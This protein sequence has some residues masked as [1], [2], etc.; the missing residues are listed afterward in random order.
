VTTALQGGRGRLASA[1]ELTRALGELAGPDG[2]TASASTFTRADVVD[3]LAKRLPVAPTAQ[4]AIEQAERVAERF[5]AERSVRVGQD[6]RLGVERYSTPEL[7]D[8]EQ[9]LVA[10]AL[11]RRDERCGMVRPEVVRAVLDRH[12]TV[13]PDQAAMVQDVCRSGAGV[14]PVVGRA[15]SG[16][17]WALGLAREA[18]ELD[19]YRVLGA[20]PTGIAAVGLGDE[21]FSEVATVDRLLYDLGRGSSSWTPGRCWWSMRPPCLA[22]A[23]SPRCSA[24]PTTP[25]PR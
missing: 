22:P 15:G 23:S 24:T 16:K 25:A 9:R 5:V 10:G 3:A 18:L 21:G 8:R 7:L 20:A 17:T 19:G 14:S 13:G 2:L 11:D 12:P 4:Q 1:E 6:A